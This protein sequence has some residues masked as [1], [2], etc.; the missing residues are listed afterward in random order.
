LK[1]IETDPAH[2]YSYPSIT[3]AQDRLLL[4]YYKGTNR[5]GD[6]TFDF[7]FRNLPLN[8]LYEPAGASGGTTK[9]QAEKVWAP[10]LLNTG[11]PGRSGVIPTLDGALKTFITKEGNK[12]Y[13]VISRDGGVTWGEEE[14]EYEGPAAFLPLLDQDGEY[15]L[16]PM[17]ERREGD[18]RTP[19]VDYFIDIWHMKTRNQG[20]TWEAPKMIFKGYVGSINGLAQLSN[21]RIVLP[22]AEWIGDWPEGPPVG[23]NVSTIIYSDDG[24]DT[25]KQSPSRLTAPCYTDFNGSGY[26]ACEPGIVELKD[27]RVYALVRTETGILYESYSTDGVQW[28]D[29]RPS[30]FLSSDAPVDFLRLPD[31]RLLVFWNGCEK[32]PRVEGAGV[33]GGRDALHAAISEDEGKT[34]R[35]YREIYRDPTRNDPPQRFGDRGTAYPFAYMGTLGKVIVASGQGR[36]DAR[37]MFD[38]G[39]LL[40]THQ[41][42]DFSQGLEGWSVFKSIGPASRWW[43]NRTQGAVLVSH[44][45][46]AGAKAL[47]IRRP[48]EHDGDGAIW[49][50]PMGRKGHLKARLK[51]GK[52]FRGAVIS[53]LD[54]FFDPQDPNGDSDAVFSLSIAEGGAISLRNQLEEGRWYDLSFEWDLP[55]RTCVVS[56]DGKSTIWLKPSYRQVIGVNYVRF[57]SLAS[58]VDP[59]GILIESV[60][61]DVEP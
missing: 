11:G 9:I 52:G 17:I 26:G 61:V 1:D 54:R 38:P 6:W 50:F 42:D 22:F 45:D 2:E 30:R 58:S 29:L 20:R 49:N 18:G 12:N 48:N 39:W 23:A 25:W 27:G 32:P 15:H 36:S 4:T 10:V 41:R 13:S 51:L 28:E 16:F 57:R 55:G 19:A 7:V 3:F 33:Y 8:W 43:R 37:L 46:K 24:G 31:G 40:E 53:L 44:P 35:G 5:S 47:H 59:A 34:W 60:Q 21:G 56:V 14:F